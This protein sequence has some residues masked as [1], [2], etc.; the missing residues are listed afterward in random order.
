[1][2]Q[3][4]V[5][6]GKYYGINFK[7]DGEEIRDKKISKKKESNIFVSFLFLKKGRGHFSTFY[8]FIVQFDTFF[9][10]LNVLL[11]NLFIF[12]LA[13]FYLWLFHHLESCDHL[14]SC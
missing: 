2:I 5:N 9:L 12:F 14:K 6:K 10:S 11:S 8:A 1:M 7:L 13:F 4:N 3:N